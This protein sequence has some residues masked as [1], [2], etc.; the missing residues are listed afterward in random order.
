MCP[1][2]TAFGITL[3][4]AHAEFVR[5]PREAI[6]QGSVC[7]LPDGL[8][9]A[10]ASLIEPLS[11][12]VNGNRACQ[13]AMGESVVVFGAGPIGLMHLM[14]A[15]LCGAARVIVVDPDP[16]RLAKATEL[17]ATAVNPSE[18]DVREFVMRATSGRGADVAVTACSIAAVQ[19][20]AIE[21]MAPFGRVCFFGGLPK[22]GSLV[23]I[24]SN[25]VHYRQLIL[26]GTTGGAPRDFRTAMELLAA[27]RMKIDDVVSHRY[28]THDM[29]AAFDTALRGPAM[30]VVVCR[31]EPG[32]EY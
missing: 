18:V 24:D 3:D 6:V 11:C 22:D 20:Q 13:I 10:H 4:G 26:T 5:I 14:L 28:A 27:G 1:D 31:E 29:A 12:A 8:P 25:I 9:F 15:R 16:G 19:E 7:P 23:R 32:Q 2:Y 17:G 21:L 30:K